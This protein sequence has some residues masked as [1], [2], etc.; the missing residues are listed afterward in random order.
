MVEH[1]QLFQIF[2]NVEIQFYLRNFSKENIPKMKNMFLEI[3]YRI[4]TILLY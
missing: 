1:V 2:M 4:F 3:F